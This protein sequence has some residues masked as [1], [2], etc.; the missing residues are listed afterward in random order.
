MFLGRSSLRVAAD[1]KET[2][3]LAMIH[4][5]F[6]GA[7]PDEQ[8]VGRVFHI[9]P[10]QARSLIRS[11]LAK[12]QYDLDDGINT[13]YVQLIESCSQRGSGG[14]FE[15]MIRSSAAVEGLNQILVTLDGGLPKIARKPRAGSVYV[16]DIA[17]YDKL[18]AYFG[19]PAR[20]N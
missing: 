3:L 18:R 17:S 13:S 7:I 14:P 11:V 20:E 15:V 12:Y 9:T 2:R 8:I 10:T 19:L 5:V 16:V 1:A 4:H 6:A